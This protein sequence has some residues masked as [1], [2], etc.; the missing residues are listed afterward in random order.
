MEF[1]QYQRKRSR[2]L[3]VNRLFVYGI[4]L[5]EGNRRYYGMSNPEYAVVKGYKT[6]L[7]GRNNIVEA[8]VDPSAALTGLI[9]RLSNDYDWR[10]LDRLERGY[11]RIKVL[12]SWAEYNNITNTYEPVEAYMYTK[13]R[14]ETRQA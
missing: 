11:M 1:S 13:G 6:V 2:Y 3:I 14:Y 12:T 5:D 9:V 4:F 7:K 10:A 8:V